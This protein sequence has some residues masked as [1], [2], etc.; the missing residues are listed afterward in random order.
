MKI[1][2]IANFTEN[3]YYQTYNNNNSSPLWSLASIWGFKVYDDPQKLRIRANLLFANDP[4]FIAYFKTGACGESAALFNF[5]ANKSGFESRIVGTKADDHAWNEVKINNR[6]VQVDPTIYYYYYTS[7]TTYPTYADYWFDN[8]QAYSKIGW[9]DGGY[10]TVFVWDTNEDLSSKYCNTSKFSVL[11]QNCEYIKIIPEN[12]RGIAIDQ[13]MH[14]SEATFD[15][16]RKN[17]SVL[18]GKTLLPFLLVREKNTTVSLIADEK[19]NITS[20]PEEIRPTIWSQILFILG[21]IGL[22]L[23]AL[24]GFIRMIIK[25]IKKWM[26]R[27]DTGD[28]SESIEMVNHDI[29]DQEEEHL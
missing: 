17:Y 27:K 19:I 8:P 7:P 18:A 23:V 12:G 29:E 3:G 4:Y 9:A 1:R 13:E 22:F 24:I 2:E 11:C 15:L 20:F 6:W 14:N 21:V 28:I 10:S 25:T 26:D 16:G 5:V